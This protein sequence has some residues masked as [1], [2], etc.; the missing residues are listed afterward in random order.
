MRIVSRGV[1]V[2]GP[3]TRPRA[4]RELTERPSPENRAW[5]CWGRMDTLKAVFVIGL[6][7]F[8]LLGEGPGWLGGPDGDAVAGDPGVED[9]IF[10]AAGEAGT[11]ADAE[12]RQEPIEAGGLASELIDPSC[13]VLLALGSSPEAGNLHLT[14]QVQDPDDDRR[15]AARSPD[16]APSGP[17]AADA[18]RTAKPDECVLRPEQEAQSRPIRAVLDRAH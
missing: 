15:I 14:A 12:A 4:P 10:G 1:T 13:T 11:S 7:G 3:T 18:P 5:P 2:V 8:I 16:P 17:P 9:G 6:G